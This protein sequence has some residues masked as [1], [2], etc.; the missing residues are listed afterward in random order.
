LGE[1][2]RD[3]QQTGGLR[4]GGRLASGYEICGERACIK[5]VL[6]IGSEPNGEGGPIQ[7][8]RTP[9]QLFFEVVAKNGCT[10]CVT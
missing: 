3:R 6:T 8:Q 5:D 7:Q 4:Y 2:K 10:R 9:V 1:V